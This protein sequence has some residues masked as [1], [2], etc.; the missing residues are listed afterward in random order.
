[1]GDKRQERETGCKD[2]IVLVMQDTV[3]W[4]CLIL[5]RVMRRDLH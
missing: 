4:G 3:Y 2:E 5:A 1:M